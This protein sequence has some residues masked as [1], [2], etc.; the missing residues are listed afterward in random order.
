MHYRNLVFWKNL[1]GVIKLDGSYPL[2]KG[3]RKKGGGG[4]G[5]YVDKTSNFILKK[6]I[7]KKLQILTVALQMKANEILMNCVYSPPNATAFE[8]FDIIEQYLD[9]ILVLPETLQILWGDFNVNLI[10]KRTQNRYT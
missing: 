6:L 9:E 3:S 10:Q 7:T 1:N 4:V 8:T 2:L 5:H